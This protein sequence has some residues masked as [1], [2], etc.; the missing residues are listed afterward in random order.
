[1]KV[2]TRETLLNWIL[3]LLPFIA[4]V[5]EV[6]PSGAV[7]IFQS[8]PPSEP[9][10]KTYSYFSFM[11]FGNANFGPLLTGVLTIVLTLLLITYL[12]S[13]Q[14]K[15]LYVVVIVSFI[16]VVT[17]LFPLTLGI[18]FYSLIGLF[19]SLILIIEAIFALYLYRTLVKKPTLG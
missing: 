3:L 16:S 9:I 8:A 6:M 12:I 1:M 7:L 2:K 18:N 17:S 10:R 14:I 4:L 19:I 15:V 5:L 13:K 11:T